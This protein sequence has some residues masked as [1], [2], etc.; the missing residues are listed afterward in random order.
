[1][2][3]ERT[4]KCLQ[5]IDD[6]VSCYHVVAN[7]EKR[8]KEIRES[9]MVEESYKYCNINIDKINISKFNRNIIKLL[10]KRQY[11]LIS[12]YVTIRY[13]YLSRLKKELNN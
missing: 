12:L 9:S 3:N 8:F 5:F 1:M 13:L 10:K 4:A 11:N 2:Q 7:M 6:S